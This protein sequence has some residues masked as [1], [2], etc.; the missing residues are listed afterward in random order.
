MV[1]AKSGVGWDGSTSEKSTTGACTL[2]SKLYLVNVGRWVHLACEERL[3]IVDLPTLVS[4][5][6]LLDVR[7]KSDKIY[8]CKKQEAGDNMQIGDKWCNGECGTDCEE[9]NEGESALQR[10]RRV[11]EIF[12]SLTGTGE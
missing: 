4:N 3:R 1:V 11:V 2:G 12:K 5:Y 10:E 8:I 7:W 6:D 9:V